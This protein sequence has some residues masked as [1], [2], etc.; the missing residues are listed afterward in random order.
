MDVHKKFYPFDTAKISP[1][2]HVLHSHPFKTHI[3]VEVYMSF[4]KGCTF[5]HSLQLL[6]NWRII[7]IVMI[8]NCRQLSLNWLE[9]STTTFVVLS[10][11]GTSEQRQDSG[12]SKTVE[13]NG[14][15]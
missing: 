5:C 1:R 3:Q 6:L 9:I 13:R 8:A 7:N 10:V 12:D 4:P 15:L 14:N 11:A 2:K